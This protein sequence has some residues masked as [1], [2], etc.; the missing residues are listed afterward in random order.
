MNHSRASASSISVA[1]I[2]D[3][4]LPL[5]LDKI[6]II[7]GAGSGIGQATAELFAEEGAKVVI[8][9]IDGKAGVEQFNAEE[10]ARTF[11]GRAGQ[12]REVACAI[13]FLAS[14]EA[15]YITGASLII[16]G[17]YTAQ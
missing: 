8:V 10:G 13:L 3:A 2:S 17:G 1:Q 4:T 11:L 9:D 15:S 5:R 16:D 6:A 14:D 7:T 12:P